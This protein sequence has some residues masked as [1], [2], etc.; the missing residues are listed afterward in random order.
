MWEF[1]LAASEMAFAKQN[2]KQNMMVFQLQLTKCKGTA[3][4]THDHI[5]AK[6]ARLPARDNRD[7]AP[8]RLTGG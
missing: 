5:D 1:Y 7:V 4:I 6:E 8:L 3:P 2:I